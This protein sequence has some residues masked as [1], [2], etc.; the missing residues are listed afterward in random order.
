MNRDKFVTIMLEIKTYNFHINTSASPDYLSRVVNLISS[1]RMSNKCS[2]GV[3]VWSLGLNWL[4][5]LFLKSLGVNVVVV[6]K[7]CDHW[8]DC[9]TWK[10]YVIKH[11]IG[12][13]FLHLDAGN[14][15]LGDIRHIFRKI[16]S[17]GFFFIDQGQTLSEIT[18]PEYGKDYSVEYYYKY[19]VFAAGNIGLNKRLDAVRRMIDFAYQEALSGKGLGFSASEIGRSCRATT[20]I[21]RNCETFRHDQTLVNCAARKIIGEFQVHEYRHYAALRQAP[22]VVILNNRTLRYVEIFKSGS[23]LIYL[24]VPYMLVADLYYQ[25]VIRLKKFRKKLNGAFIKVSEC[26]HK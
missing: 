18:P 10:M 7:F 3:T 17:D 22:D 23:V 2:V 1:I 9:Y 25:A 16:D 15:V 24:M 6:P 20:N 19:P 12:E 13:I 5:I 11:S 26:L 4:Q 8:L 14:T 21:I